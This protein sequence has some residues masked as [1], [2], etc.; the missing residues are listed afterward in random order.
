MT[1]VC[2][3]L[4]LMTSFA[5]AQTVKLDGPKIIGS[6]TNKQNKQSSK[7]F[8]IDES[9]K[10]KQKVI[11]PQQE[12][13]ANEDITYKKFSKNVKTSHSVGIG[14]GETFLFS[15]FSNFGEDKITLDL[16]YFYKASYT[17]EVMVD[18]HLSSHTL[19]EQEINLMGATVGI[20][21]YLVHLDS[22]SP[23][24]VAG[25]GF[26]LPTTKELVSATLTESESKLAFGSNFG[27][28]MDLKLNQTFTL[29]LISLYHNP[30]DL[31]QSVVS[32]IEGSYLKLLITFAYNF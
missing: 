26:Y 16:F 12:L 9:Y 7:K 8:K 19:G 4:L 30:F 14:I 17:F 11:S 6:K 13:L 32:K 5:N 23:Y 31:Q 18:L 27:A 2:L 28:G 15:T 3:L 25:L 24:I 21:S 22:F 20:K 10:A 1:R 29:G